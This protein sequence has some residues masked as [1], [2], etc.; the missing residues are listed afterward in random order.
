[1]EINVYEILSTD[2]LSGSRIVINDNFKTLADGLN[3][4]YNNITFDENKNMNLNNVNSISSN[5]ITTNTLSIRL[6]DGRYII[7]TTCLSFNEDG[8]LLIK[9]ENGNI[10]LDVNAALFNIVNIEPE[11]ENQ[12]SL[13]DSVKYKIGPCT[14]GTIDYEFIPNND[15]VTVNTKIKMTAIPLDGYSFLKWNDNA[16]ANPC[17]TTVSHILKYKNKLVAIFKQNS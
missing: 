11:N 2:S 8:H 17:I 12:T 14:G 4:L 7:P 16:T 9:G 6:N 10:D 1:M 5:E 13:I 15:I 3:M